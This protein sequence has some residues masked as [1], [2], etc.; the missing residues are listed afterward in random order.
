MTKRIGTNVT[1]NDPG[2]GDDSNYIT[3]F[4]ISYG[5]EFHMVEKISMINFCVINPSNRLLSIFSP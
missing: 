3:Q 1:D 4:L 5:N 2:N